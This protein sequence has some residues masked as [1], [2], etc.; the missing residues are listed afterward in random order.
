[1]EFST[2][3]LLVFF[4]ISTFF[5]N[6]MA[7]V[8]DV[9]GSDEG[10]GPRVR[11]WASSGRTFEVGDVLNFNYDSSED[12]V[13]QVRSLQD[14]DLCF[15]LRPVATYKSGRDIITLSTPGDL[16]FISGNPQ[17]CIAGE[18]I[19]VKVNDDGND[20]G[21]RGRSPYPF[22]PYNPSGYPTTSSSSSS[23]KC[24]AIFTMIGMILGYSFF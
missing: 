5:R 2:F 19:H 16:Y 24:L 1:M 9:G 20:G 23:F 15:S 10:W 12:S 8:Y 17:K 22:S 21:D 11:E 3:I 7:N 18:K 13:L 4:V 6:S 14:Y